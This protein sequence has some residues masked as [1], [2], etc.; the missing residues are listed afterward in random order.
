LFSDGDEVLRGLNKAVK[1]KRLLVPAKVLYSGRVPFGQEDYLFQYSVLSVDKDHKT[2]VI[3]YDERCISNASDA[4][5]D[6]PLHEENEETI[7]N[8]QIKHLKEHHELYNIHLGHV[9]K[10][11]NDKK[12]DV[13]KAEEAKKTSGVQDLSDLLL[14]I[15]NKVKPSTILLGEFES[16]GELQPHIITQGPNMGGTSYKQQWKHQHSDYK[17]TWHRVFGKEVFALDKLLKAARAIIGQK[18]LGWECVE[19]I[20]KHDK[21]PLVAIGCA[22]G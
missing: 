6:F 19:L 11:L 14:I 9:N 1:G 13:C 10:K 15:Q 8:Y 4:F 17:F 7:N 2:L 21:K 18:C 16:I 12:E 22:N 20:L 3:Q 5:Q